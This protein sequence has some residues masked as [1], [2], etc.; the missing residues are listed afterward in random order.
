VEGPAVPDHPNLCMA[1]VLL[2]IIAPLFQNTPG[3]LGLNGGELPV[4]AGILWLI[5]WTVYYKTIGQRS[6]RDT[7]RRIQKSLTNYRRS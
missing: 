1:C 5:I 2:A 7:W 6:A 3:L 4:A